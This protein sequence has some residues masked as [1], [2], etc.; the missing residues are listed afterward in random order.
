MQYLDDIMELIEDLPEEITHRFQK[1]REWDKK[2]EEHMKVFK[3]LRNKLFDS[4]LKLCTEEKSKICKELGEK[5]SEMRRLGEM[6]LQLA[7]RT[8]RLMANVSTKVNDS[9]YLC[10]IVLEVESAGCTDIIEKQFCASRRLRPAS[11]LM[12]DGQLKMEFEPIDEPS[13]FLL[14]DF[15][16]PLA[17]G[18]GRPLKDRNKFR[19]D[20]SASGTPEPGSSIARK[21]N[22]K[23]AGYK[24][25]R[26]KVSKGISVGRDNRRPTDSLDLSSIG[27][28]NDTGASSPSSTIRD[29][30]YSNLFPATPLGGDSDEFNVD[31]FQ[32][33]F[34]DCLSALP[35]PPREIMEDIM[36]DEGGTVFGIDNDLN[37]L[38]SPTLSSTIGSS[39]NALMG[40]STSPSPQTQ[41]FRTRETS[42]CSNPSSQEKLEKE[43]KERERKKKLL[44]FSHSNELSLHGRP[45]KL[46]NRA[47]EM[48]HMN[49]KKEKERRKVMREEEA[50]MQAALNAN[51]GLSVDGDSLEEGDDGDE[52]TWCLCGQPSSGEMIC[53]DNEAN[54]KIK[55][56]HFLCVGLQNGAPEGLWFCPACKQSMNRK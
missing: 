24:R 41:I 17:R 30:D 14:S 28:D 13:P 37:S 7:E 27:L 50:M 34:P 11:S 19:N 3:E 49:E 9:T 53:C 22:K 43:L 39:Q 12:R 32:G 54:C 40:G 46:T 35:S 5:Y 47:E 31:D 36:K 45:R 42:V 44:T 18:P 29:D 6:K 55:W 48:I 51:Q 15:D 2:V 10:K 20:R 4:S 25:K 23:V 8:Q 21:N 16:F 38:D 1:I 26:E 33:L 56:F 52:E